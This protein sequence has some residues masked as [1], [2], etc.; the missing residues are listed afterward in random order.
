M[1]DTKPVHGR[2]RRCNA[3]VLEAW[4]EGLH[5]RIDIA[6]YPADA[7]AWSLVSGQDVYRIRET[8]R[9]PILTQIVDPDEITSGHRYVLG[10]AC[11]AV[12]KR[13]ST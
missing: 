2:C 1:L 7:A 4:V 11:P 9:H 6:T 10:H 13:V 3:R 5:A 12:A 8:S